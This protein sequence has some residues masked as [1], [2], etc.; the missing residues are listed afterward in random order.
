MLSTIIH[1]VNELIET[2]T[3]NVTSWTMIFLE[4][5]ILIFSEFLVHLQT[6]FARALIS[7]EFSSE[8]ES[9]VPVLSNTWT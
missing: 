3:A 5:P 2:V 6:C 9:T 1:T 8:P 7:I 4:G